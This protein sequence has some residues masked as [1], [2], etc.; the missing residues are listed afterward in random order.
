MVFQNYGAESSLNFKEKIHS[1][2]KRILQKK[3]NKDRKKTE[4]K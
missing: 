3:A 4:E 1:A 2:T